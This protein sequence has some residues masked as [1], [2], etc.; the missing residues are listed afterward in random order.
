[1]TGGVPPRAALVERLAEIVDA[2]QRPH[3]VR[4]AVDGPDA[5]GKTT[6]ADELAVALRRRGRTVIRASIDGF[7]RPRAERHRRGR[8]SPEGYYEDSFDYPA[9]R[10]ALLDPL[11][12]GGDRAYR[13]AV[14]DFRIDDARPEPI[15]QAS[16][17]DVLVVD[18]VFLL[19]P[20]LVD[21]WDLRVF[22]SAGF[23]EIVRRATA[24]DAG[25]P[26]EVE[27][28]YRARYIP[29]QRLYFAEAHPLDAADLVVENDDP[30]RPVLRARASGAVGNG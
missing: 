18:G 25:S 13:A 12:P 22:V 15:A 10:S 2:V 14:F 19:R 16:E 9:F 3:P 7:H 24:R 5:A 1:V 6:L 4:V 23:D 20:E 8:D 30:V 17:D 29:G 11:G 21:A 27:R 26:D 28:R